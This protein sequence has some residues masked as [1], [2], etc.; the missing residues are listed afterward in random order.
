MS[1]LSISIVKHEVV[2]L[3]I[4]YKVITLF[5]IFKLLQTSKRIRITLSIMLQESIVI[6]Y[7]R[8][9]VS[10]ILRVS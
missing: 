7:R 1:K 3:V 10:K 4:F 9:V 8:I 6:P 5:Q 2:T